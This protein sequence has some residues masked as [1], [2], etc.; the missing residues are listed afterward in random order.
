MPRRTEPTLGDDLHDA[1]RSFVAEIYDML[2]A[3]GFGDLPQAATT[4]FRE[5]D[6]EGSLISDL[7]AQAGFSPAIMEAVVAELEAGGYVEV[8]HGRARPAAR[9]HAAFAAGRRALA[10]AEERWEARLGAD[11]FATFRAVLREL[12]T[13]GRTF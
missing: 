11:R 1:Y 13:Y 2:A 8:E 6:G 3:A 7:A 10:E 5:I 12:H 4:V 9:G